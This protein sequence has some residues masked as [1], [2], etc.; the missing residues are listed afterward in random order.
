MIPKGLLRRASLMVVD[1]LLS[2]GRRGGAVDVDVVGGL[3]KLGT[4][5]ERTIVA[6]M[7]ESAT[8]SGL[9]RKEVKVRGSPGERGC[10]LEIES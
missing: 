7:G 9:R 4:G 8:W 2:L 10:A 5:S 6:S 1:W 3:E